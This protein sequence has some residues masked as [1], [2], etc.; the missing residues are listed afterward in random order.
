MVAAK[1][2]AVAK[3]LCVNAVV[4]GCRGGETIK[5]RSA[6]ARMQDRM[7]CVREVERYEQ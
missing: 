4:G 5:L 2:S 1:D 6:G 3:C 7:N